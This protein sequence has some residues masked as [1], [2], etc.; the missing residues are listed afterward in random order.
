MSLTAY[1]EGAVALPSVLEAQRQARE[2]F[3][4][5]FDDL[6]AANIAESAVRLFT[7]SEV[8]P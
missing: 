4:R 6:A 3:G 8:S 5:L 7:A 1:A 2:A